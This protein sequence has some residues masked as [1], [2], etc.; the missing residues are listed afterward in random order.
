VPGDGRYFSAF[1]S[2][3]VCQGLANKIK[4]IAAWL[5]AKSRRMAK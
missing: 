1:L 4:K 5:T 2:R 3:D